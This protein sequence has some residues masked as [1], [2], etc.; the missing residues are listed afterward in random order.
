ME[1]E[2]DAGRPIESGENNHAVSEFEVLGTEIVVWFTPPE[3]VRSAPLED[4]RNKEI[5]IGSDEGEVV[6]SLR[7][8]AS[9]SPEV[10]ADD[11]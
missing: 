8:C 6:D 3:D 9:P 5:E 10:V 11:V 1:P 4:A 2:G 7:R